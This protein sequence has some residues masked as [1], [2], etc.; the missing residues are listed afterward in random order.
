MSWSEG[1]VAASRGGAE[2]G[3][4][5]GLTDAV[6]S[7][8]VVTSRGVALFR[9]VRKGVWLGAVGGSLPLHAWEVELIETM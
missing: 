5:A 9:G 2:S 1:G 8:G 7:G 6:D 4:M 3:G